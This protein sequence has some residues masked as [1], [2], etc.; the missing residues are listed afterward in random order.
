[1]S[2]VTLGPPTEQSVKSTHQSYETKKNA[3]E[4]KIVGLKKKRDEAYAEY[5][6]M[7]ASKAAAEMRLGQFRYD[8]AENDGQPAFLKTEK[9][10]QKEVDNFH[11]KMM[12]AEV[13]QSSAQRNLTHQHALLAKLNES[14]DALKSTYGHL[15]VTGEKPRAHVAPWRP[16][17]V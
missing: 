14:H 1:M 11:N 7:K 4:S 17:P 5:E 8:Y 6:E 10:I 9:K 15:L 16:N 12:G 3:L 13:K 2:I